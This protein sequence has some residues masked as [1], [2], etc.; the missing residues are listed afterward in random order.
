MWMFANVYE[1]DVPWI[2]IG[3]PVEVLSVLHQQV[4]DAHEP[5]AAVLALDARDAADVEADVVDP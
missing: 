1:T 5:P 2:K 3:Q 4:A